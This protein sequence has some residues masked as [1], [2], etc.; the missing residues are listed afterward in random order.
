MWRRILA[1]LFV[2]P[3]FLWAS[4]GVAG[5]GDIAEQISPLSVTDDRGRSIRLNYFAKRIISL[6]PNI[7]EL[8]FAAGAGGS[9]V[10]VSG[11]SDYPEAAKSIQ[12]IGDSSSLDLER[13]IALKPDLVVAWRS[14]NTVSDI[15][16]LEKLGLPVFVTEATRLEDVSRLLRTTG[17]LAGTSAQAESAARVYEAE[18]QQIRRT[19]GYRQ[20]VRVFQLIWHQPLMT[21]NGDHI[22][23]DII[24]ICGGANV[25]ASASSLTPV[26]SA[27]SLLEADP[28]AIISSV[29]REFAEMEVKELLRH[30]PRIS[31]VRS[32]HSFFVHPDLLHRQTIRMLQAVKTV[33]AQLERV[34]SS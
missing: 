25:F 21:V 2:F 10:G 13:I 9:L 5:A 30:V 29:S 4:V 12:G 18:L 1:L 7:T 26:V 24:N 19:Y 3:I 34:R 28:Q 14:G 6:S 17:K 15:E 8:V 23:S 22:I 32:S 31:A 11:Y 16:K 20:Q 33:C 27:E